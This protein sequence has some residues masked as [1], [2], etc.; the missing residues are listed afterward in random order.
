MI[1]M[2][3]YPRKIV[4]LTL[5]AVSNRI[6]KFTRAKWIAHRDFTHRAGS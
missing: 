4:Y 1:G 3:P 2:R 5:C 6:T